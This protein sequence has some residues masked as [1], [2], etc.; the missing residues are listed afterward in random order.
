[1]KASSE[2]G[3]WAME[4]SR[5]AAG[6]AAWDFWSLTGKVLSRQSSNAFWMQQKVVAARA[7]EAGG[8][9]GGSCDLERVA[10]QAAAGNWTGGSLLTRIHSRFLVGLFTGIQGWV[11]G[12]FDARNRFA[13]KICALQADM[14]RHTRSCQQQ[15]QERDE[16]TDH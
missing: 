1:M 12:S 3:L 2:S 13:A 6:L 7:F 14:T 10:G 16:K 8:Q 9:R 5:G 11:M 4:I 15:R